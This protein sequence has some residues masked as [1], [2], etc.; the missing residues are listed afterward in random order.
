[1]SHKTI[2]NLNH[3]CFYEL[4]KQIKKSCEI[5]NTAYTLE[6]M[7]YT[8]L[9]NFV[10]CCRLF[11][12]IFYE[13]DKDFYKSIFLLY[14]S[15]SSDLSIDFAELYTRLKKFPEKEKEAYWKS[16]SLAMEENEH[17]RRVEL[18]YTSGGYNSDH[19]EVFALVMNQ[20]KK[21]KSL[22]AL[23]IHISGY[24]VDDLTGFGHLT[25][26][27]LDAKVD[28][29]ELCRCCSNNQDLRKLTV[30]N[31]ESAGRRL[32]DIAPY[33]KQV[34]EFEF[35]MSSD[36]DASKYAPFYKMPMLEH[37]KIGGVHE[38][39]TLQ[40]LFRA[41]TRKTPKIL[42]KLSIDDAL[43]DLEETTA[44]SQIGS[45]NDLRCGFQDPQVSY[46]NIKPI[47]KLNYLNNLEVLS[48]H[49]FRSISEQI[50]SILKES[51]AKKEI[52]LTDCLIDY[53]PKGN[54][55]LILD[56]VTASDY[57]SLLEL[58]NFDC[59]EINGNHATGT[60]V[61]FFEKLALSQ[62]LIL[63]IST[64]NPFS[65]V[66][67]N[68]LQKGWRL[69]PQMV[70]VINA[71]EIAALSTCRHLRKLVCGFSDTENIDLLYNLIE[72]E[73]LT[74][75]TKPSNGS[76]K[77]LFS[78]LASRE[79]STLQYFRL[80]EGVIDSQE[81]EMLA[82]I[83]SLKGVECGFYD[84][85][86]IGK[87]SDLAKKNLKE[88]DIT[89]LQNFH[90]T[91]PGIL[92]VLHASENI[93]F[94]S[95][96]DITLR[97]DRSRN[98]LGLQMSI[99]ESYTDDT[100]LVPLASVEWTETLII[101][102]KR[103]NL[104]TLFNAISTKA[105]N[106]LKKI[107]ISDGSLDFNETFELH[108]LKSLKEFKG[109]LTDSRSIEHLTH[110]TYLGLGNSFEKRFP[111]GIVEIFNSVEKEFT[112]SLGK[113]E[114]GFNQSTGRLTL[115]NAFS[116]EFSKD[117]FPLA[118]VNNLKS[119]RISGAS[120][121]TS[122]Q[123]FLAQLVARPSLF[124]EELI[125]EAKND[126]ID[127]GVLTLNTFELKEVA[128]IKTLR[129]L[130]CGF[131]DAKDFELLAGLPELNYLVVGLN[132]EDVLKSLLRKLSLNDFPVPD[133]LPAEGTVG[134]EIRSHQIFVKEMVISK[135]QEDPFL[136]ELFKMLAVV[137]GSNLQSLIVK[138]APISHM[139]AEEIS[140]IKSLQ[141]LIYIFEKLEDI[142][143]LVRLSELTVLIIGRRNP[144]DHDEKKTL[145]TRIPEHISRDLLLSYF[146][147]F[148]GVAQHLDR[149]R[150]VIELPRMVCSLP[151]IFEPLPAGLTYTLQ[152]LVIIHRYIDLEE[153]ERIAQIASLR[154]LRC[155][156][157][158][159]TSFSVLRH[160]T[161]LECLEIKSYP[162]FLEISNHLVLCFQEC[163]EL[164]SIDLHFNR[165]VQ[166][167]SDDFIQRAIVALKS[168][169]DPRVRS[170]LR[171]T[172]FVSQV[173]IDPKS[174][175]DEE[176]ISLSINKREDDELLWE[177]FY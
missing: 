18:R 108:N 61:E 105:Y 1:M 60:L 140:K 171:L 66:Y 75:T 25:D 26:L 56:N 109:T 123:S 135:V 79:V 173:F 46:L 176:Y 38:Q 69:R 80:S 64:M 7:K 47:S 24:T 4:F 91:S 165:Q 114:V 170:P 81:A 138:G 21:S 112:I 23:K 107:E 59:L 27:F 33:C 16:L 30:L 49:D 48:K 10:V 166:C 157:R 97:S 70:P 102:I 137:I 96:S 156:F 72:L 144:G 122:L 158:E 100:L 76:L 82:R 71:Q 131:S 67:Q 163:P 41:L 83:R 12:D 29:E 50:F 133:N 132:Q 118:G 145:M 148:E 2:F 54:L 77:N 120:K 40:S 90:E 162:K 20:L 93:M 53:N 63:T 160:L 51:Q 39:G 126:E 177:Y 15:S 35:N 110:L 32:A 19:M 5:S 161:H 45:L 111:E 8:D 65:S 94:V 116:F 101:T 130:K 86:D 152:E 85:Q 134:F 143:N 175:I 34:I 42:R 113:R 167:I 44:L 106:N 159:A 136:V 125:M 104:G 78:A 74:I 98:L 68:L 73:E 147:G 14:L 6:E 115:R 141:R 155:G 36:C 99:I 127:S 57:E 37:L 121:G 11:R 129:T 103:G 43:L 154:K 89:S 88:L 124:L 119:V 22:K 28:L 150:L 9:I 174:F 95:T 62:S 153:V 52:C 84:A 169:R 117:I 149:Q 3:F 168:V 58:P 13:W 92:Q 31:S 172:C 87:F 17:L 142:K 146:R 55:R 128:S 139:E 151:R 164:Q